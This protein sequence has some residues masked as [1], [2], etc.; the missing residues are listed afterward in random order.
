MGMKQV[1]VGL[2]SVLKELAGTSSLEVDLPEEATLVTLLAVLGEGC[3]ALQRYMPVA[4]DPA[5]SEY[6]V[7]FVDDDQA[8]RD[9]PL[10]DGARVDLLPPI[11][12]GEQEGGPD[13][14]HSDSFPTGPEG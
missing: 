1:T 11:A 14:D 9:Q 7:I 12:G 8:L 4:G 13:R 6:L 10:A 5:I 2:T 3:P